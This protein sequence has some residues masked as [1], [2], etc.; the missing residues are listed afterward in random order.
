MNDDFAKARDE[1]AKKIPKIC[2]DMAF[3]YGATWAREYFEKKFMQSFKAGIELAIEN[4]EK[5]DVLYNQEYNPSNQ[6]NLTLKDL[7]NLLELTKELN[8]EN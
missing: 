5:I 8:H 1:M 7:H 4:V 2:C 6:I 3:K